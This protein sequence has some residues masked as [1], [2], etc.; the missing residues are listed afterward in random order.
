ML[1]TEPDA[2]RA[3]LGMELDADISNGVLSCLSL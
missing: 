3:L 2:H 1:S